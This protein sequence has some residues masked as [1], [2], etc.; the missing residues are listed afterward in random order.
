[1]VPRSWAK[2][3]T[4]TNDKTKYAMRGLR[5]KNMTHLQ[6]LLQS[7]FDSIDGSKH[8]VAMRGTKIVICHLAPLTSEAMLYPAQK[9]VKAQGFHDTCVSGRSLIVGGDIL[10]LEDQFQAKLQFPH[11]DP[12]ARAVNRSERSGSHDGS[13][14]RVQAIGAQAQARISEIR[15]IHEIERLEAELEISLLGEVEILQRRKVPG[16]DARTLGDIATGVPIS[17]DGLKGER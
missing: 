7:P 5:G 8:F 9:G 13:T 16:V 1:M 10:A 4:D 2:P 12:G 6:L 3:K 14:V 15:V 11:V 17:P